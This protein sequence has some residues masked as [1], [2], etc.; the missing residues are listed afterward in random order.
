MSECSAN[1][2]FSSWLE[3]ANPEQDIPTLWVEDKSATPV[4]RA[5]NG[6]LVIHA[7]R[8]D[9]LTAMGRIFV[10]KVRCLQLCVLFCNH[11][12]GELELQ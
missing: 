7:L 8:P 5:V 4:S 1:A 12:S 10:E 2:E 3:C 11:K 6:L 9:R